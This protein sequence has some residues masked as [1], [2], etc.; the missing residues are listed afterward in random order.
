MAAQI[1]LAYP[2]LGRDQFTGTDPDQDP[3]QFIQLIEKKFRFSHGDA[4]AN[5]AALDDYNFRRK[6]YFATLVRGPAAEWFKT[7][8]TDANTWA[9]ISER[10]ITRFADGRNKFRHRME[11][12]H[13]TRRDG[14][15]IKYF[16]HRIKIVVRKG[17]PDDLAGVAQNDRN[18]ERAEQDRQRRQRCIDYSLRDLRPPKLKEKAHEYLMDHRMQPGSNFHN[19]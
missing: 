11:A 4:P 18:A 2:D 16:L 6:S 15:E 10:F 7:S 17:W 9:E 1:Y 13:V 19:Q 14:E 12:E 5:G 3:E 8:I